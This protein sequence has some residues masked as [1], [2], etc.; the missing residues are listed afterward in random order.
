MALLVTEPTKPKELTT[1]VPPLIVVPPEKVLAPVRVAIEVPV[2]ISAPVPVKTVR[3]VP[4]DTAKLAADN[5]PPLSTEFAPKLAAP[6][7]VRAALGSVAVPSTL[8]EVIGPAMAETVT[9][10]D[11]LTASPP[12]CS[13]PMVTRERTPEVCTPTLT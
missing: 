10:P 5:E 8:R 13:D 7:T 2:L 12:P 1:R 4:P 11:W 9:M 6:A 3:I